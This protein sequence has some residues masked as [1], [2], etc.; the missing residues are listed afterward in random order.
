[1]QIDLKNN[2]YSLHFAAY[3]LREG[4]LTKQ[5]H[6]SVSCEKQKRNKT[7][8]RVWIGTLSEQRN[9]E[10]DAVLA[11]KQIRVDMRRQGEKER[12]FA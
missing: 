8:V 10:S 9:T 6:E 7:S 1:M 12:E 3:S 11:V 2:K 4:S 5:R